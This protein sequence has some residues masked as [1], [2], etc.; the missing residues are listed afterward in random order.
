[1][2]T[3]DELKV[4]TNRLAI[5]F[6]KM[7]SEFFVLLTEFVIKHDFTAKRLSDAVNHVISNFQYKEPNI[8]DIIKFDKRVKLHTYNEVYIATGQ[9]PHPDFEKREIEGKMY[10][11]RK[12][13]L[14]NNE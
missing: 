12:T 4:A 5:A 8:S 6:P 9:V 1:M 10:Y 13:D 11:I 14:L 3:K 7:T 2:P